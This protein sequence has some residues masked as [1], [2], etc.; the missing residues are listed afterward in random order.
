MFFSD[1]SLLDYELGPAG[2]VGGGTNDLLVI[3]GNLTLDGLLNV[4][5][6]G[7]F[8][9]GTYTLI[10][11]TGTLINNG[12]DVGSLPFGT[13]SIQAGGGVVQLTVMPEPGAGALL[14]L[15]LAAIAM[16]RR[17][18]RKSPCEGECP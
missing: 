1:S 7:G 3:N 17:R 16:R 11:Y 8:G 10:T 18:G 2:I 6:L 5:S 9:T 12:L 4:T 13:G 15:G 14:A